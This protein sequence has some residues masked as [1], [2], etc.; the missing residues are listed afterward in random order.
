MGLALEVVSGRATAPGVAAFVG[1]TPSTG[2]SFTVRN[3][4]FSAPIYLVSM[5]N[6]NNAAGELRLRSPKLHD[7]VRGLHFKC[8]ANDPQPFLPDRFKQLLSPQDLLIFEIEGSAVGGQ[9]ELGAFLV[10]YTDLPGAAGRFISEQ[11]LLD[12]TA[13]MVSVRTTHAVGATGDYSGEV[14]FNSTDDLLKANTDYAVLGAT[15][16]ANAL[17]VGLRGP[18]TGNL[19]VAVPAHSTERQL[20]RHW[21]LTLSRFFQ[22]PM[23]PVINSA[24]KAGT[25]VD[26]V[27]DQAAAAVS[28]DW[29]LAELTPQ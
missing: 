26:A 22:M 11:Q 2:N 20:T 13:S 1:L 7:N 9:I 25:L 17:L 23:I 24:N 5:W 14:A 4:S 28:A 10:Y 27:Q 3:A 15:L 18:D 29:T 19:R 6:K 8:T 12:R 21:F 16:S